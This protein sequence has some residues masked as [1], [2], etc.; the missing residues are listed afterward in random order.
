MR[1]KHENGKVILVSSCAY[2]EL[3]NFNL[4]IEHMK[5]FCFHAER[6]FFGSILRQHSPMMKYL[7]DV[8]EK[9]EE[10]KNAAYD[11][12]KQIIENGKF[13]EELLKKIIQP[14]VPIENYV[15]N[16]E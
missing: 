14:L 8:Q 7:Q 6:E 12:G 2:W 5:E 4:L 16:I 1:K 13:N 15:R 10:I 11:S 9:L 3:D